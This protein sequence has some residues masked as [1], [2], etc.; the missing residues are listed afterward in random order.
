M[1]QR[2][3]WH[4]SDSAPEIYERCLV[5]A[6]F[7]PWAALVV[8]QATLQPSAYV[9]DVACG[10]GVVARLAAAQVGAGG[11]VTGLDI[12]PKMLKVARAY[13]PPHGARLD[14]R[15]GD[16]AALP[17]GADEFDVVFCQLGLQFVS[18]RLQ[19]LRE[20]ARVL[21]PGGQIVL[22][23]WR[24]LA[25]SPGFAVLAESLARHVGPAAAALMRAPFVFG[26]ASEGLRSL[27]SAAGFGEMHIRS[28]VRMVRFAS[29]E[30]FVRC[31]VAGS[32]LTQHV[33]RVDD[34]ARAALI[35]DVSAGLKNYTND[36][37]IAFP[38]EGHLVVAGCCLAVE[39]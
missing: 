22:L 35:R 9:L 18:D 13:T 33:A 19:T 21:R 16:A 4:L 27:L 8:E 20:M 32:P 24:A 10:T 31:Q 25:H 34:A 37:G 7:A 29:P 1:T 15:E 5:P 2:N 3:A 39:G 12:N 38:I 6:L 36:E 26:D 23:V 11:R 28:D 17:F 14:W 30:A